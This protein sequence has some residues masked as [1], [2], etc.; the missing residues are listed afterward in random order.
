[1]NSEFWQSLWGL[2]SDKRLDFLMGLV[3]QSPHRGV[4]S[5]PGG[6]RR[7]PLY[8]AVRLVHELTTMMM[9]MLRLVLISDISDKDV[10]KHKELLYMCGRLRAGG[11]SEPLVT[12]MSRVLFARGCRLRGRWLPDW[13][14]MGPGPGLG[15]RAR[16][17]GPCPCIG[18]VG[19]PAFACKYKVDS[20]DPFAQLPHNGVSEIFHRLVEHPPERG[21]KVHG[22]IGPGCVENIIKQH[23]GKWGALTKPYGSWPVLFMGARWPRD[24]SERVAGDMPHR[25]TP[26]KVGRPQFDDFST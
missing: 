9:M 11:Q 14:R 16:G 5:R 10:A 19:S 1:M 20:P 2:V 12:R 23:L 26:P 7:R 15:A 8:A 3:V 18:R 4:P 22:E 21:V 13:G 17:P 25:T 24:L 6:G